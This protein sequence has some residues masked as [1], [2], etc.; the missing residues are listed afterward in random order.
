[1]S[2]QPRP[3]VV[4]LAGVFIAITAFLSLTELISALMDWG[5]VEMKD[6]LRPALRQID[7][8]GVDVTMT[9]LLRVL[10]WASFAM[11]LYLVSAMVFAIYALRGDR[12]S[13]TASSA[14]AVGA[15]LMSLP[16]GAFGFL[17]AAMMF[18]A[19]GA[20]WSPDAR[21]WYR[22]E[23]AREAE[24]PAAFGD[25]AMPTPPPPASGSAGERPTSILTAGIVA[26][27]GS[28]LA[29][30]LA[31][32]FLGVHH[33]ARQAYVDAVLEGPFGDMV[34]RTDVELVMQVMFWIS[35]VILPVA[36]I[37]LLGGIAV[38][39]RLRIGRTA[40]I[41]WA[42]AMGVVGL[43]LLPLGLAAT[44]GAVVVLLSLRRADARDWLASS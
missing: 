41:V 13:R 15:G 32:L 26:I 44:A 9:Q 2:K 29:V 27:L 4:T 12:R 7:A 31:V 8:G 42:W 39:A 36:A 37:G 1:V 16:L 5:S 20:L 28:V 30:G 43:F 6:A 24:S 35:I 19:A 38:L 23:A 18:L 22:G 17:Q 14:L 10:R 21:R 33:F 34:T 40:L 3:S 11:V 25:S